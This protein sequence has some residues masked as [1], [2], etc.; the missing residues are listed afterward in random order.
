M[1]IYLE[2]Q[3]ITN[4]KELLLSPLWFNPKISK[5]KL[6]LP[7]WFSNGITLVGDILNNQGEILSQVQLKQKFKFQINFL[8]YHHVKLNIKDFLKCYETVTG[9]FDQP[10][11]PSVPMHIAFFINNKNGTKGIYQNI[12][13][14]L[15]PLHMEF[16][17]K[18]HNELDVNLENALWQ[19]FLNCVLKLQMIHIINGSNT[20]YCIVP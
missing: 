1:I 4:T 18:W 11:Q 8:E 6:F 15:K 9:S 5:N 12:S 14:K 19:F 10:P 3:A 20:K 13:G 7:K 2:N 17:T 16:Q